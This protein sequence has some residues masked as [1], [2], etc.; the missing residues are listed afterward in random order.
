[1]LTRVSGDMS[2]LVQ[3]ELAQRGRGLL[4][5]VAPSAALEAQVIVC[6]LN[7]SPEYSWH[8]A[9]QDMHHIRSGLPF[10]FTEQQEPK[11]IQ[12]LV[13][14]VALKR[15]LAEASGSRP[16]AGDVMCKFIPE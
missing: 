6:K 9:P 16:T 14:F 12:A 11:A 4:A 3:V 2:G 5:R 7:E 10:L 15:L 13:D 8:D 1:M